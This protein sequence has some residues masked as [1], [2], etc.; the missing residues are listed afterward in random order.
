MEDSSSPVTGEATLV[1]GA[2]DGATLAGR[3]G[4]G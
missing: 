4:A 3:A 2:G 1:S